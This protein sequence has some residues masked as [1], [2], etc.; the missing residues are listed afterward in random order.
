MKYLLLVVL[1]TV[2][3][4]LAAVEEVPTKEDIT[5]VVEWAM[6][7][8]TTGLLDRSY[9]GN[10]VQIVYFANN[11]RY[12]LYYTGSGENEF[13]SFWVKPKGSKKEDIETF[14]DYGLNGVCDFGIRFK[15][16][17]DTVKKKFS[18][19]EDSLEGEEY[20]KYWQKLFNKAIADALAKINK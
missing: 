15:K 8:S 17:P 4:G 19:S 6:S 3:V 18:S 16:G 1:L 13:L 20:A 11:C 14:T 5:K 10:S 7:S 12:T 9:A 2:F